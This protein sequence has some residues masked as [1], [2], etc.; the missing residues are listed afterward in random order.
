MYHNPQ[1][2][3]QTFGGFHD[4]AVGPAELPPSLLYVLSLDRLLRRL[5]DEG[6]NPTRYIVPF[7]GPLTVK[8]S[9]YADDIIVFVSH[10]FDIKCMKKA[11]AKYEQIAGVKINFDKSEGQRMGAWRGGVPLPVPFRRSDRSVRF[12]GVWLW[13]GPQLEQ[14]WLEE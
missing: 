3:R 9:A 10:C 6:A 1:A 8:V 4:R 12:L 5:R 2:E 14:N 13:P 7:A 11:V